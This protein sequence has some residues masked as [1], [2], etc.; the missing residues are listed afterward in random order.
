MAA[1]NNIKK[2]E[3]VRKKTSSKTAN[4]MYLTAISLVILVILI[5]AALLYFFYPT[6]EADLSVETEPQEKE[7]QNSKP[8]IDLSKDFNA[9]L[10]GGLIYSLGEYNSFLKDLNVQ[11][12]QFN[13]ENLVIVFIK[14]KED[15]INKKSLSSISLF[16]LHSTYIGLV[17]SDK[18]NMSIIDSVDKIEVMAL[19]SDEDPIAKFVIDPAQFRKLDNRQISEQDLL[20]NVEIVWN[21][22]I[23][24]IS[25]Q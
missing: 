24:E 21:Q 23:P 3:S 2:R 6:N 20:K 17:E 12:K 8:T 4:R 5:G 13:N 18:I 16:I 11:I 14:P 1:K 19:D 15:I 9:V 10:E 25:S 22:E 7:Q